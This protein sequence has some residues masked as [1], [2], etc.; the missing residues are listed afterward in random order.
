MTPGP[1]FVL[2]L[3][4][5]LALL[6]AAVWTGFA[7]RRRTHLAF[8]LCAVAS[9][10]VTIFY[11]EQLGELYDLDSAGAITPTHLFL[12][13]LTTV[14]YLLPIASGIRLWFR[15]GSRRVHRALAFLVLGLTVV[16]AGTGTAMILM[17]DPLEPAADEVEAQEPRTGARADLDAPLVPSDRG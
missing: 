9:L 12:A 16:T 17:A 15:P 10:G 11:A 14:A 3:L 13:K 7:H 5:T 6:G 4:V 8:V 1:G 2:F